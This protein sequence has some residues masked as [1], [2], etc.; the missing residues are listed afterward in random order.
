VVASASHGQL[1]EDRETHD[2]ELDVVLQVPAGERRHDRGLGSGH[3]VA[4]Q[5]QHV[6]HHPRDRGVEVGGG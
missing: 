1:P 5:Y 4:E 3:A 2:R 6:G